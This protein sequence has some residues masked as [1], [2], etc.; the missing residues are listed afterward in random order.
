MKIVKIKLLN[1]I[2]SIR[3]IPPYLMKDGNDGTCHTAKRCIDI[4]N[5]MSKEEIKLI[6]THELVHAYLGMGGRIYEKSLDDESVCEFI[7]W[8][9]DDIVRV[10]NKILAEANYD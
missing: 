9:I 3:F 6:L 1:H 4:D 10:R 7:A 5:S 8:N 2:W